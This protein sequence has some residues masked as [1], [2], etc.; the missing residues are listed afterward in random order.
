MTYVCEYNHCLSMSLADACVCLCVFVCVCVW[1]YVCM[2]VVCVCVCVLEG[3]H[4]KGAVSCLAFS[5]WL[6]H[7]A[8]ARSWR[9]LLGKGQ[10]VTPSSRE[11]SRNG[12]KGEWSR[13]GGTW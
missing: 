4:P 11:A 8:L 9:T 10:S 5:V 6:A 1:V 2:Y 13:R 7:T 3:P 12:G